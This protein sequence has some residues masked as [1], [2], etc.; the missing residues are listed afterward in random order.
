[1]IFGHSNYIREKLGL[2]P[3]AKLPRAGIEPVIIDGIK[4]WVTPLEGDAHGSRRCKHRVMAECPRCGQVLSYG[5][6]GQHL[7][8]SCGL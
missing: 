1:M 7:S 2:A 3:K 4:V 6:M 5:R 8:G